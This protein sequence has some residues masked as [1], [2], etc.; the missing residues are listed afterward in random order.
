MPEKKKGIELYNL[1]QDRPETKNVVAA[2]PEKVAQ[3]KK[4]IMKIVAQGRT[5]PG[6]VQPNDTA[7]WDDL[8]WMSK[9]QFNQLAR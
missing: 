7:Y 9:A 5:T 3:L 6:A 4:Q 8:K 2:Y 1:S